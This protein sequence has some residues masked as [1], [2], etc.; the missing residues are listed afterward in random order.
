MDASQL[1]NGKYSFGKFTEPNEYRGWFCG[2]FMKDDH[3]CKT[4]KL[5]VKFAEHKRGD[6]E[7]PHYHKR[8]IELLIFLEGKAKFK[9]N[10]E[11]FVVDKGGFAFIDKNNVISIEWLEPSKIFAIHTPSL[12]QEESDVVLV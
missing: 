12:T 4:D 3:P 9:V 6:T 2:T 11:E 8:M 1:K 7:K 10:D 5:E